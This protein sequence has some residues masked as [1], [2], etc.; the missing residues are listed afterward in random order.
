MIDG[1]EDKNYGVTLLI[2]GGH[3][4]KGDITNVEAGIVYITEEAVSK[5]VF[6]KRVCINDIVAVEYR[7]K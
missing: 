1:L 6:K 4:I 5:Q 2:L 7:E 3:K